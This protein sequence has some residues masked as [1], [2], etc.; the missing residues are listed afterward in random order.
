M[1]KVLIRWLHNSAYQFD[2]V[3]RPRHK[4]DEDFLPSA[5]AKALAVCKVVKIVNSVGVQEAN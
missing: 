4:G 2:G 3:V 5:E 1:G